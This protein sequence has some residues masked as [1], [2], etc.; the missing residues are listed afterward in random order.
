MAAESESKPELESV[1][2]DRFA[3]SRSWSRQNFV[4]PDSGSESHDADHQQTMILAE[5]LLCIV[6]KTLKDKKKRRVAAWRQ[7]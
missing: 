2:V 7:S 6:A 1:G 4:D 5:R 3:W